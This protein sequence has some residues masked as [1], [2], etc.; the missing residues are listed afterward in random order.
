MRQ[1][2]NGHDPITRRASRTVA[3]W[4]SCA[5]FQE[6]NMTR[7][8]A[9]ALKIFFLT[10]LI[11]VWSPIHAAQK[12]VLFDEGH[13][14]KFVIE[15]SGSLDLSGLSVLFRNEGWRVVSNKGEIT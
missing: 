15:G 14:Q 7:F 13:G 2:A 3:S 1:R 12:T 11:A 4:R 5:R 6:V 10:M 9:A 8:K